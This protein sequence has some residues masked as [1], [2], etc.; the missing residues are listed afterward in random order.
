[1]HH[2]NNKTFLILDITNMN[3]SIRQLTQ[4]CKT[5]RNI[6]KSVYISKCTNIFTNLAMEDWLYAKR[7][8]TNHHLLMLWRNEPCVV[9]GRH[10]NPWME[11]NFPALPNLGAPL[12]RRNSGGGTVY[13]DLENLN[14]TFFTSRQDYCRKKNLELMAQ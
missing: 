13:H 5:Q 4:T 7:D 11:C 10:Q 12:A 2:K 8:F 6:A 1:M 3:L 14:L 9:I